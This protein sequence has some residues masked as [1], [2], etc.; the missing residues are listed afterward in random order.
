[1]SPYRPPIG[2]IAGISPRLHAEMQAD[3]DKQLEAV[4]CE[5]VTENGFHKL[6]M[7]VAGRHIGGLQRLPDAMKVTG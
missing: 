4:T 2:D 1:M 5:V 3:S 7:Y 6:N